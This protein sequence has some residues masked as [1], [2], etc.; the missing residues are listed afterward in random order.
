MRVQGEQS[1][2]AAV[3]IKRN[4]P[5]SAHQDFGP[6]DVAELT[7]CPSPRVLRRDARRSRSGQ[8][9]SGMHNFS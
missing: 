5:E 3:Q 6:F 1:V 8:L 4:L 9:P 7:N 2:A